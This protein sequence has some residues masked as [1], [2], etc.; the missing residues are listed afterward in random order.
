MVAPS[1]ARC[2]VA[3]PVGSMY[4]ESQGRC[5]GPAP[6]FSLF[7]TEALV[8]EDLHRLFE[9]VRRSDVVVGHAVGV[10]VRHLVAA[11]DVAA[12]QLDGVHVHL[13]RG[14]VEKDFTREGFVLPRTAV[15]RKA[16]GVREHGL[17][18]EARLGNAVR[19]REEHADRGGGQHRVWRR[20][21]PDVLYEVDVGGEDV[22]LVV[23]RHPGLA[24]DMA[25]LTRRH[26]VLATVLDPLQRERHLA[27][28]QQDAH[29]FA[30]RDDL[31][32]ESAAGVAHDDPH[33]LRRDAQQSRGERPQFVRCLGGRP[34]R[35][36]LRRRFPLDD[37][38]ARLHRHRRIDLLV[39]VCFNNMGRRGENLL[40]RRRASH[41]SRDVVGVCLVD[42]H[43]GFGGQPNSLS[44]VGDGRQR[45]I[46]DIHQLDGIL[47]DVAALGDDQGNGVA[48]ELHLAL[49]QRRTRS[50]RD[51][52][53][54]DRVPRFLDVRVEILGS[55]HY[56]HTGHGEGRVGIDAVDLRVGEGAADEAGVQ[57]SGPGDVVDEGAAAGEKAVVLDARDPGARVSGRNRVSH[58]ITPLTT[59]E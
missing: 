21:S 14:D 35:Q 54:R 43:V 51:V 41:P 7:A 56:A 13:A 12:A 19:A 11:Q 22:A 33:A 42:D 6:S 1:V 20:I 32:A 48:D 9:G 50:V 59:E 46:V 39:D 2:P 37:H 16:R 40:V 26:Q 18:V 47:G 17:V 4:A 15:G 30:H 49:G 3:A 5:S 25:R 55:K 53:A 58:A 29:V 23:E 34:H 8:V 44:E 57:H 24:V 36:V 10:E 31:L 28:G 27:R 45:V 52:L 38:A